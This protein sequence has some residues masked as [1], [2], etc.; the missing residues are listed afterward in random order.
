MSRKHSMADKAFEHGSAEEVAK[1]HQVAPFVRWG[2]GER[3]V[4]LNMF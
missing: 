1:A 4:I 3:F 2:E